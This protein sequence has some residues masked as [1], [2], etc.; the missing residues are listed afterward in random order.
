MADKDQVQGEGNY[1]ASREFQREQ[2]EFAK[3]GPVGEK[4]REAEEALDGPE[5]E[6]L[7]RARRET[8]EGKTRS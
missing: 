6:E 3:T 4:A 8:G 5:A 1:D 7:E 2:H